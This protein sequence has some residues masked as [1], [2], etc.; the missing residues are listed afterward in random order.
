MSTWWKTF[1]KIGKVSDMDI[2]EKEYVE[3]GKSSLKLLV[4]KHA[5]KGVIHEM[6]QKSKDVVCTRGKSSNRKRK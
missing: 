2:E 3:E 5:K 6:M 1:D 4:G